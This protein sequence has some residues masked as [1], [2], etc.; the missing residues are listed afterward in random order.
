MH[1]TLLTKEYPPNVYGGAGVHV[2]HLVEELARL[3][4][5]AHQIRVL[6]FGDQRE[7]AR[8]LEVLGVASHLE[9][10]A[11]AQGQ[12]LVDTLGR[13]ASMAGIPGETDVIHAHTWYT[14]LAGCLLRRTLKAPLVLTT[15]SL[16]PHRPWKEEQLGRGYWA[17]YW[18][19]ET[20]FREADG[21]IAVSRAMKDDVLRI[22]SV[23]EDRVTVIP[24]AVDHRRFRPVQDPA[25]LARYGIDPE[26][27]YVLLVSRITRQKGISHFLRM[28]GLLDTPAQVVLCAGVADTEALQRETADRVE[29]LRSAIPGRVVWVEESIPPEDLPVLYSHAAVFVCPSVYEP[30][31]IINLEAMACGTPVVASAV[32]GIPEAVAHGETGLLVPFEPAVPSSSEPREPERFARDLASA[33]EGL[34]QN[35]SKR[36]VLSEQARRRVEDHF[37]WPVVAAETVAFYRRVAERFAAEGRSRARLDA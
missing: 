30:F 9:P 23:P 18:I 11:D 12:K 26:V 8:N 21:V 6:C 33:V 34:L 13:V 24:N 37:S 2:S 7:R 3:E 29:A 10:L 22:Y 31:G 16:E 36:A 14:H 1:I 5:R 35:P 17:S 4:N 20:G 19:E 32:G 28:A 15:H 27:P 25:V